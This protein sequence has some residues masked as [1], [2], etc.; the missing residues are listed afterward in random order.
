MTPASLLARK[1]ALLQ[2]AGGAMPDTSEVEV[3]EVPIAPEGEAPEIPEALPAPS[4]AM[5][6]GEPQESTERDL[7]G[8]ALG[9]QRTLE[10]LAGLSRA[11]GTAIQAIS[12]VA[13]SEGGFSALDQQAKAPVVEY[14]QRMKLADTERQRGIQ[15]TQANKAPAGKAALGAGLSADPGSPESRHA[16]EVFGLAYPNRFAPE[17]LARYSEQDFARLKLADKA[18]QMEGI[19]A[20]REGQVAANKRHQ[21][22]LEQGARQHAE[23]MG[24]RWE[25]L[26]EQDKLAQMRLEEARVARETARIQHD[27]DT[28]DAAAQ[29]LGKET[30]KLGIPEA[31]GKLGDLKAL[32]RKYPDDLPG[33]GWAAGMIPNRF[34]ETDSKSLRMLIGQL[35][36][37]YQKSMTGAG[38]SDAERARYDEVTGLLKRGDSE[39]IRLGVKMME[40]DLR[41]KQAALE[42]AYKPSA[43]KSYKDRTAPPAP[44]R[45]PVK[46]NTV[47]DDQPTPKETKK[48]SPG[49]DTTYVFG[50]ANEVI[51][52]E[53]G[54][55]RGR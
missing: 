3:A 45:V 33:I 42:G 16:Q 30:V 35:G 10:L 50:A 11:G 49:K 53:K 21:A 41:R 18:P 51:R 17:Q 26:S 25:N 39:S 28:T 44:V 37:T 9:K 40:D 52:T 6:A 14:L 36:A 4:R 2:L 54:D 5:P 48:Y 47:L 13:P 31:L 19:E 7:Y 8:E 22:S 1:R 43:V 24:F 23:M 38:A 12:G 34:E 32:L 20:T 55:T 46:Q 27:Q 15:E 29:D